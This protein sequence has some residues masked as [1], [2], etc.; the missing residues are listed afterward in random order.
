M[1]ALD[2]Q[3]LPGL[4]PTSDQLDSD[5]CRWRAGVLRNNNAL[6]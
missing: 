1:K 3:P 5:L 6:A 2:T 4:P